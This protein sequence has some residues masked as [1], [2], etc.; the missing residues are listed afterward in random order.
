MGSNHYLENDRVKVKEYFKFIGNIIQ[1]KPNDTIL[2]VGCATGDLIKYLK[3][4]YPD[5]LFVGMD[6]NEEFLNKAAKRMPDEEWIIGDVQRDVIP[7]ADI[8]IIAGIHN[9]FDNTR[10]FYQM[11]QVERSF[12]FGVWN[13]YGFDIAI[14]W[15]GKERSG[16]WY[17]W[18]KEKAENFVSTR[19]KFWK[20]H[21]WE[22]PL[23][24]VP[25]ED[26]VRAWT[27]QTQNGNLVTN[28]FGMI[29]E[30]SLLEVW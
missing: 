25:K 30:F 9:P 12:I 23:P 27:I 1:P 15:R 6:I 5:C 4:L 8:A 7:F 18:S 21:D 13:K 26:L 24:M 11:L 2:D 10:W 3:T 22:M 20:W 29:Q 14:K 17:V 19:G 28:G 16:E